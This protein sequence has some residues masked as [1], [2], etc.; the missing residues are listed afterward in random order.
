MEKNA[1]Q[2]GKT[3]GAQIQIHETVGH[4]WAVFNW[5]QWQE[6][7]GRK[8][9]ASCTSRDMIVVAIEITLMCMIFVLGRVVNSYLASVQ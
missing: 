6:F 3:G 4:T 7:Q 5:S 8:V 2:T 1:C 9:V